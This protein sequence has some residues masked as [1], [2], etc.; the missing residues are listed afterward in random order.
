[1]AKRT[2][3]YGLNNPLQDVF[4]VPVV[5]N[6]APT[7]NDTNYEIGQQ[8]VDRNNNQAYI[9]TSSVSG[10]ANW[11]LTSTGGATDLE[12]LTGDTGGIISPTAQNIDILGGD[13]LTVDGA[14]S[15]LTLNTT[16]GG[17]PITPFV[18]GPPGEAGYTTIQS[19][20]DA[21]NAAGGGV[22]FVQ[23]DTWTEDLT[24]YD[25]VD[26][27][28]SVFSSVT[29]TGV[30][31]PPPAGNVTIRNCTLTSATHIFNSAVAGTTNITVETCVLSVTNGY[32]YNLLN[33]TGNL[34]IDDC[35]STGTNDGVVNNTGGSFVKITDATVGAGTTNSFTYSGGPLFIEGVVVRCPITIGSSSNSII[36]LGSV[37]T[38]T[39][40]ATGDSIIS[41]NNCSFSKELAFLDSSTVDISNSAV[42]TVGIPSITYNSSANSKIS[43]T[44][45]DTTGTVFALDG[46]GAGS[47][48]LTSLSTPN[49]ANFGLALNLNSTGSTYAGVFDTI[50]PTG[51]LIF[52]GNTINGQGLV[53]D[54]DIN[55]TPKGAGDVNI[56]TGDVNVSSGDIDI[57]AGD[58]KINGT[59]KQLQ[60]KGG[61]VT[62]F[63]GQVTLIAGQVT[64]LNTNIGTNDKIFVIRDSVGGSNALGVF[65]VSINPGTLFIIN[66]LQLSPVPTIEINDF[67]IVNY[68]IVR[69]I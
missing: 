4:S 7:T 50:D 39:F 24:L 65:S 67:S 6:R 31:T 10:S 41:V 18:V 38:G 36:R 2:K 54:T 52:T 8:W 9:L 13:L 47:L 49:V 23:A 25:S 16:T 63:I 37:F 11:G 15:S 62:D 3:S 51:K 21:A 26:I 17:Y 57:S 66:S 28:G 60:V 55:L 32:V 68:F 27:Q 46:T 33:W 35:G 44:V 64:V 1:M 19:A 29:I 22:V 53:A 58:V 48:L 43:S 61:A 42:K 34:L 56:T 59:G 12:T 45:L 30:H 20:L 40:T 14:G 5:A 69:Q